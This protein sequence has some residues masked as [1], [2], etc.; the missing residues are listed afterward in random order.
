MTAEDDGHGVIAR[1]A[2]GYWVL[3]DGR[4]FSLLPHHPITLSPLPSVNSSAVM[5]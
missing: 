4:S 2:R 5:P 1:Y 3:G